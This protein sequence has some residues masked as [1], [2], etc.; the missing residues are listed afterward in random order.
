M[1]IIEMGVV[2]FVKLSILLPTLGDRIHDIIRL[3]ESLIIQDY[4]NFEVV[5]VT[6]DHHDKIKNLIKNYQNIEIHHV[7]LERKGLSYS[8]NKGIEYCSGDIIVLS[9][10]DCW[11][12]KES[13]KIIANEFIKNKNLDVL[14]TQIYDYHNKK[15]Y[16]SYLNT[17]N[18]IMNKI[19]LMSK[20]S[21]EIAFKKNTC[22]FKFDERFG[23]GSNKYTCGEEVDFLL[24]N[25]SPDKN[26]VYVPIVTVYHP[27][28]ETVDD[29][30]K[31]IAKG[32]VYSKNFNIFIGSAVLIR[33]LLIKKQNNFYY[34]LQGYKSFKK[35]LI[36]K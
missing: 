34:F 31:I 8:R 9:D 17:K 1:K 2:I 13:L 5:I 22:L 6:Q 14:L 23:L 25:Y 27:R 28:K 35:N 15:F 36:E 3:L 24:C 33:D 32:A 21:I 16:K 7:I 10:D 11:Y 18:R 30:D 29:K 19:D 26:F 20:S 4:K 12:H